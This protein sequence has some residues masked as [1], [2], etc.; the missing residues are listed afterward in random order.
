MKLADTSI[1]Q[2]VFITML[3][4]AIVVL[5]IVGYSRIAV[6][7]LPDISLPVVAVTT[8]YPGTAPEEVETQVTKPIEEGVNSLSGVKSVRSTSSEGISVIVVEFEFETEPDKAATDVRNKIASIHGT[9]PRDIIEPVISKFDPSAAPIISYGVVPRTAEVTL[10]DL[11][12]ITEDKLKPAI[13]RDG[14]VASVEVVGGREREIRVDVDFDKLHSRSLSIL[15][16]S[17]AL[18]AENLNLPAGRLTEGRHELLLRTQGEFRTINDIARVIVAIQDGVPVYLS[19]VAAITD[20][21]KDK[22]VISRLNGKECTIFS[23]LKQS[24]T[25]TVSV[26]EAVNSEVAKLRNEYPQLELRLSSD[27]SEFIKEAKSDVML[28]LVL[29]A[30]FASLVVFL[31]FGDFRNTIITVAG[32]P[33]CIIGAFAAMY[34]LGFSVNVL[35][36]LALSVSVG[37]LIDDAIVVRENIFRHMEEFSEDPMTAARKGTSEVGLAVTATTLTIVA[38]F[39]PVAFATG[40]AGKF[41]RQFGITVAVAVLI[42]L[43]EAFTFAPVLSAYFFHRVEKGRRT[44]WGRFVA[45][46]A[47]SYNRLNAV[48]R[49]A[50]AW[51]LGH[52]KTITVTATLLFLGSLALMSVIPTGGSPKG[53]RPEYNIALEYAPGVSLA[54]A[55]ALTQKFESALR[56]RAEVSDIFAVIGSSDGSSDQAVIHVR[57]KPGTL[58]AKDSQDQVRPSLEHIPGAKLTFLEATSFTG[59]AASALVQLPIQV[60]VRGTDFAEITRVADEARRLAGAVPGLADLSTNVRPPRPE[61]QI[62]INRDR[63]SQLGVSTAQL[64]TVFR[65]YI[66]GDVA[67]KFRR[68]E[69]EIDVRV[70]LD[71]SDRRSLEKLATL[72]IPTMRGTSVSLSQVATVSFANGPTQINRENRMRQIV[73]GGNIARGRAL[74]DVTND[75]KARLAELSVPS[76]VEISYSGQS[77]QMA[78]SFQSLGVSLAL[79]IIFVYM[80]LASQFGSFLQPVTLM[81]AL[82]LAILG[83]AVA[84]LITNQTFDIM[85]FIGLI[86]LM[87]LVTKNSILLI[88]Y[89]N[90]GRAN[91]MGR[92]DAVISAGM[93]RLRPILMTTLAL[94]LGMLPV[95]FAFGTSADF[96]VSMGVTIIGGLISSTALTLI[97]VPVVYTIV[98]DIVAKVRK[99]PARA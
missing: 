23:V 26:A 55:D 51:S 52:R 22:R 21:F 18:K 9:L 3:I 91:G 87:G 34:F 72:Y 31:S 58:K 96:R 27:E 15:Q 37:L 83:A 6:D 85:A 35:T 82:P 90:R 95:A 61:L 68:A 48:Y 5:G 80:V 64:A 8:A 40:V 94:I 76:G 16:V 36:L 57:L 7:L 44:L 47:A 73:V 59:A 10:E 20:G 33:V 99:N 78:E 93:K 98:D 97:V 54:E 14:G 70:R 12:S 92:F 65:T 39:L 84:I 49:P 41:F 86:M 24:G 17:Q 66:G 1:A 81:L 2:P 30:I 46:F 43:F 11:R 4:L 71:E 25:N 28:S 32:L 60:K 50:L 63:A 29:G 67:T 89:I 53:Q 19:D 45:S 88:D 79:A 69:K 13:E 75:V 77:Q 74:G 56:E 62:L 38:V 42:S